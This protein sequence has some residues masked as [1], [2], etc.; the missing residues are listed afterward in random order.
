MVTFRLAVLLEAVATLPLVVLPTHAFPHS[1]SPRLH[2]RSSRIEA[3]SPSTHPDR[4]PAATPVVQTVGEGIIWRRSE[5]VGQHG[6]MLPP[7]NEVVVTNIFG[8]KKKPARGAKVTVVPLDVGLEP[9]ELAITNTKPGP[10]CGEPS[11]WEVELAPVKNRR[12]FAIRPRAGRAEEFPFD[13][14]VLYPAVR[15]ARQIPR[16]QLRTKSLPRGISIPTVKAAIDLTNDGLPDA[17]LVEYCCADPRKPP[18]DCDYTCGRTYRRMDGVWRLVDRS[19]P[20]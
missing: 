3:A 7:W 14:C 1:S 15:I 16:V 12:L 5:H 2:G 11:W 17:L 19:S 10:Q 18:G 6:E 20:C 4:K 13:V 8:F 9:F